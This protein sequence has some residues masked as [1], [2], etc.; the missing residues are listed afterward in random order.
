M[1]ENIGA[2]EITYRSG[3]QWVLEA[4]QELGGSKGL[5]NKTPKQL[6][7]NLRNS[8]PEGGIE[9]IIC[10]SGKAL[11][12][13]ENRELGKKIIQNVTQRALMEAPGLNISGAISEIL[14][15]PG[16]AYKMVNQKFHRLQNDLPG[17]LLR[18]QSI[19]LHEPCAASGF[20]AGELTNVRPNVWE[21]LSPSIAAKRDLADHWFKRVNEILASNLNNVEIALARNIEELENIFEGTSK[22]SNWI[23]LVFSDGNGL[24]Q[25]FMNFED[26]VKK[27][28]E[29]YFQTLRKFSLALEDATEK[30]FCVACEKLNSWTSHSELIPLVPL[31]IGGDDLTVIVSGK[32]ALPFT[33]TFLL[34]FEKISSEDEIIKKIAQTA[35]G[36]NHLSASAGVAIMKSHFP[37][38]SGYALA[39]E[40][41]SS[42]KMVKKILTKNDQPFPCSSLDFHVLYDNSFSDLE[43]L[44]QKHM[45]IGLES[46]QT[47]KLYAGPYVVSPMD[48]LKN[49]EKGVEWANSHHL[50]GL[51]SRVKALN[52]KDSLGMRILPNGQMHRLRDSLPLGPD[53]VSGRVKELGR[54]FGKMER[55]KSLLDVLCE[56]NS[57]SNL[58]R[59][60]NNELET[61]FL[62]AMSSRDF[63]G[64][65]DHE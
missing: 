27:I 17:P 36:E 8:K 22:S 44:R 21:Y 45:V 2:S 1:R 62:D 23:G 59:S 38:Y 34:E 32:Y 3:T 5:W 48:S 9:V 25:I 63:W 53:I 4:V 60:S 31:L 43:R 46:K 65:N 41:Q 51:I 64:E 30:A 56:V 16:K 11:L 29:D 40:L 52:E 14:E 57:D 50:E 15:T 20:P 24:G 35:F 6:R 55:G 7:Q 12:K 47:M 26:H 19:P 54:L 49:A 42:A 18:S 58:F 33:E 13:V 37:F 10:T 39:A 28:N 61:R